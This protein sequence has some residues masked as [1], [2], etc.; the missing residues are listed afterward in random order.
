LKGVDAAERGTDLGEAA[1]I[2]MQTI[3][4]GD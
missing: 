3:V 1:K 2:I 4:T